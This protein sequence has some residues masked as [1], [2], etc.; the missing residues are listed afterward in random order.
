M[1]TMT[2]GSEKEQNKI[3]LS[4]TAASLPNASNTHK[5]TLWLTAEGPICKATRWSKHSRIT[6]YQK[7]TLNSKFIMN[8]TVPRAGEGEHLSNDFERSHHMLHLL[9][10]DVLNNVTQITHCRIPQAP[11]CTLQGP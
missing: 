10:W 6:A 2:V 1:S 4:H 7:K 11:Q 3:C 9:C 5:L 8:R